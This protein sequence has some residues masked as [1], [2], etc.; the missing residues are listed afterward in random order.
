MAVILV[1]PGIIHADKQKE[2]QCA[3]YVVVECDNPKDIIIMDESPSLERDL[4]L[5]AAIN[6][7][8]NGNDSTGRLAFG[9]IIRKKLINRN[10]S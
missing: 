2:L 3:G 7:L 1:K 4:L 9:N 6:A 5:D 8:D 10:R